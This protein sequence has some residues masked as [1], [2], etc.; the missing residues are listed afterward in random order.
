[1]GLTLGLPAREEVVEP[2]FPSTEV[3]DFDF[4]CAVVL[5]EAAGVIV[6]RGLKTGLTGE[7]SSRIALRPAYGSAVKGLGIS[8]LF[9]LRIGA[10]MSDPLP[11]AVLD[12]EET[13][14]LLEV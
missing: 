7:L 2:G 12:V 13:A 5:V 11:A 6:V 10:D 14:D 8:G 3:V 4:V 9:G 1:M